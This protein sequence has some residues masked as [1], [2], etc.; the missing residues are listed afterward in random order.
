MW[1]RKKIRVRSVLGIL[2]IHA[3]IAPINPRPFFAKFLLWSIFLDFLRS[4]KNSIFLN[5][6]PGS[7][8]KCSFLMGMWIFQGVFCRNNSGFWASIWL[9]YRD[10]WRKNRLIFAKNNFSFENH[11]FSSKNCP[12]SRFWQISSFS[13]V[14]GALF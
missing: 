5:F 9:I 3:L 7:P 1:S 11:F 12:W 2:G 13:H 6:P 14:L 8:L 4:L 10:L